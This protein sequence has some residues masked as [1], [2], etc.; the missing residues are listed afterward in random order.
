MT[1]DLRES[2][3]KANEQTGGR[4]DITAIQ[5]WARRRPNEPLHKSIEWDN[6]RAARLYRNDQIRTL[7]A[8]IF[9]TNEEGPRRVRAVLSTAPDGGYV[10][11]NAIEGRV[12][13]E[14]RVSLR[15]AERSLSEFL[16]LGFAL[17][18]QIVMALRRHIAEL[19]ARL[20]DI[21]RGEAA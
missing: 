20:D 10:S 4:W 17:N 21:S 11:R 19:Q 16:N 13:L 14:L 8:R 1:P 5:E 6:K 15:C 9:V 18:D 7:I 3:L 12:E 2:L